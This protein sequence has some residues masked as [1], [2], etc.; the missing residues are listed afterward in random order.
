METSAK[1]SEVFY[2]CVNIFLEEAAIEYYSLCHKVKL[3][4]YK[5]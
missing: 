3:I 2:S 1:V 5:D 4:I